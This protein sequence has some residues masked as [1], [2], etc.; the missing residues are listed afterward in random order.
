MNQ[1]LEKI[2]SYNLFNNLFP[3]VLFVLIASNYTGYNFIQDDIVLGVFMYYFIGLIISRIGSLIIEPILKKIKYLNFVDY[4]HFQKASDSDSTISILSEVNNMYRTLT[5][6]FIIIIILK[7]YVSLENSLTFLLNF[8]YEI[9]IGLL[10][11]IFFLSYRK[12]TNYI[13]SRVNH[14]INS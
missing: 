3:G 12:Q 14:I 1:L 7:I 11:L 6:L 9:L 10:L 13:V 5:A 8:R 2:S 4:K